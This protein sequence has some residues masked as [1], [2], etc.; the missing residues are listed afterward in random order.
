[1]DRT[2]SISFTASIPM[3]TTT[4]KTGST[5]IWP[6]VV[7]VLLLNSVDSSVWLV[8]VFRLDTVVV[9]IVVVGV[10]VGAWRY[11]GEINLNTDFYY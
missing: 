9:T 11:H 8:S 10:V 5:A 4:G 2:S 7:T 6:D 3:I 1:M